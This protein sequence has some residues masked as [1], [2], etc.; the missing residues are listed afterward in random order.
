M[1]KN[2]FKF[3]GRNLVLKKIL[4]S[5]Y[6]QNNVRVKGGAYGS[7]FGFSDSGYVSFSSYR[8]P[9]L[10]KTLEVYSKAAEY[11]ENFSASDDEMLKYIIGTLSNEDRP[12]TAK[13]EGATAFSRYFKGEK[14]GDVQRERDEILSCTAQNVRDFATI[15]KEAELK[16][17]ICVYGSEEKIRQN[18]SLFKK[19]IKL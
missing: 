9:N 3:N 2:G 17:A 11:L 15:I 13:Q 12:M 4:S 18:E 5:D 16:S 10:E 1:L 8:D 7:W 6:L 14:F 19:V